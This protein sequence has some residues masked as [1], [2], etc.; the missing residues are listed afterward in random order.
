MTTARPTT[1]EH[2]PYGEADPDR[3]HPP[4][5]VADWGCE[6]FKK[7]L[8]GPVSLQRPGRP[9]NISDPRDI[10]GGTRMTTSRS[11]DKPCTP[12][13]LMMPSSR[14]R[15]ICRL[16]PTDRVHPIAT[17]HWHRLNASVR[18]AEARR[19]APTSEPGH[20]GL[21]RTWSGKAGHTTSSAA[22]SW[23][24]PSLHSSTPLPGASL[25]SILIP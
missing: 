3:P 13:K 20:S 12:M 22:R 25:L 15:L 18:V 11:S 2:G 24:V 21:E 10:A 8:S 14:D 9:T 5:G 16:K 6:E 1:A 7:K 23:C 19:H 17:A 4:K